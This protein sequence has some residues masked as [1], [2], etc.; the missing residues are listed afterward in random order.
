MTAL[1][2]A[3][4]LH[5]LGEVDEWSGCVCGVQV[6]CACCLKGVGGAGV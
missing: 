6:S 5:T 2:A 1:W 4:H 3:C